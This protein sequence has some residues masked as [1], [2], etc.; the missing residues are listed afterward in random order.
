VATSHAGADLLDGP[1]V[2]RDLRA[3]DTAS[4]MLASLQP[5]IIRPHVRSHLRLLALR[6]Q[7][8]AEA[9]HGLAR[10][11]RGMKSAAQQHDEL[12]AF[13]A[14][15]AAGTAFVSIG[16]SAGGYERLGI[17]RARWP[18][19]EAFR[20]GLR[21]RDLGDPAPP[22]WE[23]AYRDGIDV[24]VVVGSHHDEVTD[25]KVREVL[26]ALAGSLE[27]V[28]EETGCSLT[29]S[30]G[31]GIEHFGYVDGR[32]QPLFIDEDLEDERGT[33][34]G[35]VR[36]NPL[37]PLSHVL[38]PD[39][40]ARAGDH[41]FGSY[42]VYRK[43]EQNVQ[44][45]KRQEQRIAGELGLAGDDAERAG[46][47]LIGRFEDG[48]PLTL[49]ATEGVTP[50]PNDFTYDDD[51]GTRCPLGAH[52]R[53]ANARIA[54]PAARVVIARRGQGY[55]VRRDDPGDGDVASKPT[56]G[57]GLL[58]M[59]VVAGLERQFESLQRAANGDDGGPLDAVMGQRRAGAGPGQIELSPG[60]NDP[61]VPRVRVPVDPVVT[62]LGGEYCFLP[63][64]EFLRG[65]DS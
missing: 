2:L 3:G 28:A 50:I 39:P 25:R 5:N 55:G 29:N 48:T 27:V 57:V 12:R 64:L 36:W 19:G 60:W 13:R 26:G 40:G 38:V 15:G 35:V 7:A 32:S 61:R 11:A 22:A 46:A 33:G 54:D 63:S 20:S 58:F 18:R 45:F 56:G 43:L 23:P 53:V 37:V 21:G 59:A 17:E 44:A 1:L 41:A 49:A 6:V 8:P 10:V 16:L 14:S 30:R 34:D 9:R 4:R 65:L 52:I 51:E 24:L 31:D 42:L 47:L 62:L